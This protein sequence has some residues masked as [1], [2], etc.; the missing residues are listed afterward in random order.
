MKE[1]LSNTTIVALAAIAAMAGG[2]ERGTPAEAKAMLA[3]AVSHYAAVGRKQA[4]ADFTARRSPFGDRDLYVF[5]ISSDRVLVASGGYPAR[6]GTSA[7]L[8]KDAQGKP[9][10]QALWDAGS[11]DGGGS[12]EYM[13]LNPASLK[14]EPKISFVQKLG[15]DVCGV[16][17][18]KAN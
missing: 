14:P 15:D 5:C 2:E 4:L 9:L 17:A 10:R 12:L 11:H 18:Y 8:L 3:K 16:G 6:V 1:S 13:H 7:D